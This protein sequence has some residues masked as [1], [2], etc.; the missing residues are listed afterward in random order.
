MSCCDTRQ[1]LRLKLHVLLGERWFLICPP[2]MDQKKQKDEEKRKKQQ[3]RK[4]LDEKEKPAPEINIKVTGYG[5]HA[6]KTDCTIKQ[7]SYN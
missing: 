1:R 2:P 4:P 7:H 5:P 6:S 3:A